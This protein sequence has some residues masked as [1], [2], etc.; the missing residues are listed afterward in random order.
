MCSFSES[1]RTSGSLLILARLPNDGKL[2]DSQSELG[3]KAL[4]FHFWGN[5]TTYPV[6]KKKKS[7]VA[8]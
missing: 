7:P 8:Q 5:K 1:R 4:A 2:K 6:E 3:S